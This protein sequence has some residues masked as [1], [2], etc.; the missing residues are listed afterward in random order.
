MKAKGYIKDY[1]EKGLASGDKSVRV[2]LEFQDQN[3][4]AVREL[5]G[6]KGDKEYNININ[7]EG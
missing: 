5:A 1:H 2:T 4:E 3:L 6:F 7:E